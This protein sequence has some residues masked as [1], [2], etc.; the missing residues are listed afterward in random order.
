MKQ[1]I[2]NSITNTVQTV[3]ELNNEIENLNLNMDSNHIIKL[4]DE[5][6]SRWKDGFEFLWLEEKWDE[7]L[8][9][10]L[11]DIVERYYP[12]LD[13]C[14]FSIDVNKIIVETIDNLFL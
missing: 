6:I 3:Q 14:E 10:E 12:E 9:C 7:E 13:G 1:K 5:I 11:D 4:A 2:I 8:G